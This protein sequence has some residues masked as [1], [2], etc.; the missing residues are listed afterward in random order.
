M[1]SGTDPER[2]R[3]ALAGLHYPA[4]NR[5]VVDQATAAGADEAVVGVLFDLPIAIYADIDEVLNSIPHPPERNGDPSPGQR[6]AG[7]QRTTR[8]SG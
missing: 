1:T 8:D 2:V 6:S 5:A 7:D 3:R 4:D